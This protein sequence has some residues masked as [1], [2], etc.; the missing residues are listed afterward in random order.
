M[1]VTTPTIHSKLGASSTHRWFN[2]PGSVSLIEA[3]EVDFDSEDDG[4]SEHSRRGTVAHDVAAICLKD[5]R[6]AW[7]F[8]GTGEDRSTPPIVFDGEDATAVQVYL[9]AIRGE[10]KDL[11]TM[12]PVTVLIEERFHLTDVHKDF[13]GT[14]DCTL[15]G[16]KQA[17]VHDYKHGVG[18]V[19]EAKNNT[20]LMQYAV[21]ALYGTEA[22]NDDTFPVELN[23]CQPRAFH[24][25]GPIRSWWTTVGALKE[26]L[27]DGWLAAARRTENAPFLQPGTW[28]NTTFCPR[29]LN[30][31][32]IKEMKARV[33][34]VKEEDLP[35]MED[36]ELGLFAT[37]LTILT[38]MKKA[39]ED[40]VF[41]RLRK[42]NAVSGWKMVPKRSDRVFKDELEVDEKK[43]KIEDALEAEFGDKAYEKKRVSPAVAEKLPGGKKFVA[44]W[45]YKPD[46]GLTVARDDDVRTGQTPRGRSDVFKGAL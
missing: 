40:E 1:G 20:Q 41:Q 42:G 25:D 44:Q 30:C 10:I 8:V 12:G 16:A 22:W 5:Q 14:T 3:T 28:C 15:I 34:A 31:P 46:N 13:F 27:N 9:D 19:V 35:K 4:G 29:R 36:W 26:W 18:I 32:A 17:Q 37:E 21:G 45:A 6:E 11:E 33:M 38:G 23:I 7:E 39:A 43:V 2:C 24:P